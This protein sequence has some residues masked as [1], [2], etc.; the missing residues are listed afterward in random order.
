MICPSFI[1]Y[2]RQNYRVECKYGQWAAPACY[3]P[4]FR[5]WSFERMRQAGVVDSRVSG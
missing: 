5:L 4:I 2:K 3:I 1:F